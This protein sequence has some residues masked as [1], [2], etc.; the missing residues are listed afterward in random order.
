M[1]QAA[2][3]AGLKG[4]FCNHSV[5]KTSCTNLLHAGVVP[6]LIAQVS[7][8]KNVDSLKNCAAAS[9][10]QQKDMSDMLANPGKIV[11]PV[12]P[13]NNPIV[14]ENAELPT[15]NNAPFPRF[16]SNQAVSNTSMMTGLFS[17]ANLH[18]CT[19][20]LIMHNGTNDK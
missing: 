10:K 8:H 16:L 13:Q 20:H 15:S 17:C 1:S 3:E 11:A 9:T 7:G 12:C 4:K 14:L 6:T 2:R 18:R 5:R 19:F